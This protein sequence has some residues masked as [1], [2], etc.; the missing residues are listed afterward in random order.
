MAA[1]GRLAWAAGEPPPGTTYSLTGWK[2]SEY[3]V[4]GDYPANR[5][6]HSGMK[7]PKRVVLRRWDLM[8]R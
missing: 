5:N 6:M 4:F 7:L 3:F 8:G 2:F 1:D